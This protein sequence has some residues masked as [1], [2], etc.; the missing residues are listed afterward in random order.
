MDPKNINQTSFCNNKT[1]HIISN[2]LKQYLLTDMFN[3]SS[4]KFDDKYA[5]IYNKKFINNFKNEH[6]CCFKSY[7]SPYLLYCTRINNIPYSILIDKKINKDHSLPKMFI[8]NYKFDKDIYNGSLFECELV[9]DNINNWFI[10]IGDVYYLRNEIM[11]KNKNIIE[12]MNFIYD[13]LE[14]HYTETEFANICNIRVK[15]YYDISNYSEAFSSINNLNYKVRGVY[16]VPMN[17]N[18]A[19]ILYLYTDD[20]KKSI[21]K[22][23]NNN[24]NINFKVTKGSK[25]EIYDIYL[26]APNGYQKIDNLYIQDINFSKYMKDELNEIDEI[27]LQCKYN[28]RFNKWVGIKKTNNSVHHISDIKNA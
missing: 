25:P 13:L 8:V 11:K 7:G 28:T 2:E 1:D 15:R 26:R 21:S 27:I 24:N 10:L 18:Y 4:I 19:N 14:N 22:N 12:R 17:V 3:R 16:I 23:N 5:R 20:D 6:I 9:R